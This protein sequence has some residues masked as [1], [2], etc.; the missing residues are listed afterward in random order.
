M[1]ATN[2]SRLIDYQTPKKKEIKIMKAETFPVPC[3]LSW[4]TVF[5]KGGKT[6]EKFPGVRTEK[7]PDMLHNKMHAYKEFNQGGEIPI[8]LHL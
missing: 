6:T 8:E 1:Q 5:W 7:F 2:K 4:L 3:P